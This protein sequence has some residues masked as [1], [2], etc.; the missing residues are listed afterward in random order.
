M[1]IELDAEINYY[2][3]DDSNNFQLLYWTSKY[4]NPCEEEVYRVRELNIIVYLS[5]S[6]FCE[7]KDKYICHHKE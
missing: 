1:E 2:D 3:N 6:K 5:D 4:Q 7:L